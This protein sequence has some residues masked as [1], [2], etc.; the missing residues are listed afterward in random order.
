MVGNGLEETKWCDTV[1]V[2]FASAEF[3]PLVRVGGLAEATSGLV[4]Q[5]RSDGVDVEVVI[6]D[7]FDTPLADETS[8]SLD[9]PDWA[10]PAVARSGMSEKAG[11]VTFISV[12]GVQRPNPY[13]DANGDGWSDNPDRF[14]AFSAAVG[15]LADLRQPDVVHC[16][17]WHTALTFG[18]LPGGVP[19]VF[20]I[21][22]LGYQGWTS[23]GW[24]DRIPHHSE[25]FERH[26]G[27]NPVAGAITL[28]DRVVAVSPNYADE[29][30]T[31]EG[32]S[33]LHEEM[34]ALGDRLV[35]IRNGIDTGV[36]NPSTDAFIE[37]DYAPDAMAGKS[38]CREKLLDAVGWADSEV[39]VVG[40]VTRLVEQKGIDILLDTVRYADLMP[41]RLVIL[42]SGE[43]WLAD[44][45]RHL[46]TEFPETVAFHDGYDVA[47][48]HEIFAGADLL[49]MPS[50]F[51]PCGLAQM[52]AMEYGTI[53]VVTAVGG[54]VDTVIDAD[55]DPEIGNGFVSQ[56][57][58]SAGFVDA[59][60][61]AV[62][63][64][65]DLGRRGAIQQRG[66][67]ADWSWREPA[68][69]QI[70]MYIEIVNR[71]S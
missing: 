57:V 67:K 53:P 17:D 32:G 55:L 23:G 26:G 54:L 39:P 27:T 41:F 29:I 6:P 58:D 4:H 43:K 60:H 64:W 52:Q 51:E 69:R 45:A 5:L 40:V 38:V 14:F 8:V 7:Y 10:G 3:A 50:R 49:A 15:A 21:H 44:Y 65:S 2:L 18:F 47:F 24:L 22:T 34:I 66:M 62:R 63:A 19:T 28:A 59:L 46:A 37:A 35:G 56:S 68:R 48:G 9:V 70:E 33:G 25:A 20:T 30:R 36:W 42:G 12:P 1:N 31:P 61:R 13:V 11:P 71:K 16:N